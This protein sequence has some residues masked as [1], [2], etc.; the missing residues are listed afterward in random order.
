MAAWDTQVLTP[1]VI[2]RPNGAFDVVVETMINVG[3]V[4]GDEDEAGIAAANALLVAEQQRI[5]TLL[6][7]AWINPTHYSRDTPY[8]IA[9][10]IVSM[11][12]DPVNQPNLK[13]RATHRDSQESYEVR[14]VDLP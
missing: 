10:T 13:A 5:T 14:Y 6:D 7:A 1:Y 12:S 2:Y 4:I 9:L 11:L 8:D 3:A